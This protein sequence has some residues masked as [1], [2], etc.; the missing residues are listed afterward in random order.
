LAQ[1]I[2]NQHLFR[3][4][5][6]PNP[7]AMGQA[8]MQAMQTFLA[9]YEAGKAAGRYIEASLPSIPAPD[10]AFDLALCSHYLFLYSDQVDEATHLASLLELCRLAPDVRIF[11]LHDLANQ[12]SR[13]LAPIIATLE[14][15]GYAVEKRSVRYH[16]RTDDHWMLQIRRA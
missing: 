10:D 9:D 16:F 8:R 7:E 5:S 13:H 6:F 14:G 12:P 1:T 15:R 11:P 2:Q 4:D 3:W